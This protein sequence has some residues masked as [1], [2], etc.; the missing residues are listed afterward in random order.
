[1]AKS[2]YDFAI[3]GAGPAGSAC[4]NALLLEG[5]SSVVLIDRARF[6]RDKICGDGIGPGVIAIL[7]A[8]ELRH[9][10]DGHRRVTQMVM[11]SP[12]GGRMTLNDNEIRGQSPLGYVIRRTEF[13]HALMSAAAKR[14][15]ADRTGWTLE[16]AEY[17]DGRWRLDLAES[18]SGEPCSITADVLIGADGATSRVRRLLGQPFNHERHV[19]VSMRILAQT[20]PPFP[21]RQELNVAKELPIPGYAWNFSTGSGTVNVGFVCDTPTYK[22]S[23]RHLREILKTYKGLL[24]D[25]LS[26]DDAT[27][28]S[29]ILPLASQ[30]PPLAY[31]K[32]QAALIGDAASMINPLTG[33]GIFYGMEAG[34]LLGRGLARAAQTREGR[35][36]ALIRYERVFRRTFTGHFRGNY[37]LRKLLERPGLFDRM[38]RAGARDPNLCCDCIEYMMGNESGVGRTPLYRL[39]L[40]TMVA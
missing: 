35:A 15:C 22:A 5:A 24:P 19:S 1:M 34:L 31:P 12:L 4:A 9:I 30:M 33:E 32:V 29:Q 20:E 10:L 16:G 26:Y 36:Q 2:H 38:L 8:L 37:Y 6:P 3:V 18:E 11:T 7:E 17:A 13:D 28:H 23:G 39:A 25:T 27:R 40:R 14:G 21:P